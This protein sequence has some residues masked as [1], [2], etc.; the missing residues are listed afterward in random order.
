MEGSRK[1]ARSEFFNA[2]SLFELGLQTERL[3]NTLPTAFEVLLDYLKN[4]RLFLSAAEFST[5]ANYGQKYTSTRIKI[6]RGQRPELDELHHKM[7]ILMRLDDLYRTHYTARRPNEPNIVRCAIS[8]AKTYESTCGTIRDPK[9][10]FLKATA[11]GA[12]ASDTT[13]EK[14]AKDLAAAQAVL[15]AEVYDLSHSDGH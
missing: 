11:L 8:I 9:V 15:E 10:K 12:A 13:D 7:Y 3:E 2:L 14:E 1:E 6:I 4:C 5:S